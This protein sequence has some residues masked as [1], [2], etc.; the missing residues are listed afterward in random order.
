MIALINANHP[1][2]LT[3][4][5]V[6]SETETAIVALLKDRRSQQFSPLIVNI[7]ERTL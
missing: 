7:P 1:L 5:A 2:K 3:G 6:S 4:M